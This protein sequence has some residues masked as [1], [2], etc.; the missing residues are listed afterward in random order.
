MEGNQSV[1]LDFVLSPR[2]GGRSGL[3]GW[4]EKAGSEKEKKRENGNYE[5]EKSELT[6]GKGLGWDGCDARE[7]Q[8]RNGRK[9]GK[10]RKF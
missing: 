4:G 10:K 1:V 8:W 7:D 6:S 3:G 2:C 5:C 9:K